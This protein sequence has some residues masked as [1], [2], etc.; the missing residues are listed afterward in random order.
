MLNSAAYFTDL[1]DKLVED[2][3]NREIVS[4]QAIDVL[5]SIFHDIENGNSPF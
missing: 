5:D 3:P 1:I 2:N 4:T